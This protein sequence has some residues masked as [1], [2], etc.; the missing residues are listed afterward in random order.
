MP[1][2]L[3]Y[4]TNEAEQVS[5]WERQIQYAV[6][7]MTPYV[8]VSDALKKIYDNRASTS[9]ESMR[10]SS[11]EGGENV[12]RVKG[13]FVFAWTDQTISNLMERNPVFKVSPKN[14]VAVA[15]APIVSLSLIHI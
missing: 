11:A 7:K 14:K 10:D 9:R 3:V 13:N 8:K 15:G 6:A 5:Y 12:S 1:D 4:P 2:R